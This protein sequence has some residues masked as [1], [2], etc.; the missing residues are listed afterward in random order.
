[1]GGQV[2]R[3]AAVAAL[4]LG[5]CAPQR[6]TSP[7]PSLRTS[8]APAA[9]DRLDVPF[10]GGGRTGEHHIWA[11][12]VDRARPVGLLV[13][14]HGDGAYE[15]DHPGSD[16]CLGGPSGLVEV[17]RQRNLVLVAARTP[18]TATMTWWED[19]P[20]NAAYVTA[21]LG[22]LGRTHRPEPSRLWLAGYSGGAQLLTQQLLPAHPGVL[23]AGAVMF[24]GGGVP[25]VRARDFTPQQTAQ[26]RLAWI[27]GRLDT[28]DR[29]DE[30]F[31]GLDEARQGHRWYGARGFRHR[32]LQALPDTTHDLDGRFGRLLSPVLDER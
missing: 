22:H 24:G 7:T 28:A 9:V 21:L 1:M 6:T 25:E 12:H 3:R 4:L 8:A 11:A 30:G 13:W 5:G 10:S 26:S 17:A 18:D 27:V 15:V 16:Y 20:A 2:T 32:S 29:S 31:D 23:A 14:F 19:G